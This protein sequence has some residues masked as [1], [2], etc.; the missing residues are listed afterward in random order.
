MAKRLAD[1]PATAARLIKMAVHGSLDNDLQG[2]LEFE[3][4]AQ[5]Q[6]WESP[7]SGQKIA[8]FSKKRRPA[9][10]QKFRDD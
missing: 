9:F 10:E 1:A 6:C 7:D 4:E 2:M 8:A 5:R 3:C